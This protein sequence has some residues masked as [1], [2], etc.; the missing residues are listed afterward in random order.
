M[1]FLEWGQRGCLGIDMKL[2]LKIKSK[3]AMQ[4]VWSGPSPPVTV[5]KPGAN[6]GVESCTFYKILP[7][8]I[9]GK[10]LCMCVQPV[11]G[12]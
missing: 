8:L 2:G 3:Y 5:K 6:K 9:E 11:R 7:L 12:L 1:S 4:G 10:V